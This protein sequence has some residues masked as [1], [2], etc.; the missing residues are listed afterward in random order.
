MPYPRTIQRRLNPKFKERYRNERVQA[1]WMLA[2]RAGFPH[3]SGFSALIR[4]DVVPTTPLIVE[5]LGRVADL[6]GFPKDQIFVD[7]PAVEAAEA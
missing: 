1:S 7:E 6:L 4:A 5:R 3:Q 2:M